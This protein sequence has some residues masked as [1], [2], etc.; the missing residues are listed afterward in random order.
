MFTRRIIKKI[1]ALITQQEE[2]LKNY[3]PL[4]PTYNIK[5]YLTLSEIKLLLTLP[6]ER[7]NKFFTQF[8]DF[9]WQRIQDTNC[10]Y[11]HDFQ[12][13]ANVVCMALAREISHHSNQNYLCLLMPT[14]NQVSPDEYLTS[15]YIN[16]LDLKE[17]I[18]SDNNQRIINLIDV[19]NG[20]QE[21]GVLK[22]N[23]LFR[24]QI[25][26][27][28]FYEINRIISRHPAI[29]SMVENLN[30]RVL[31]KNENGDHYSRN[32]TQSGWLA[33]GGLE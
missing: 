21:D 18:L 27:L 10:Q 4:T 23:S 1:S 24:G 5:A 2:A 6:H 25:K 15:S 16:K 13:P 30:A 31:Y 11:L 26:A 7:M 28:S 29:K 17:L 20:A 12:N 9:R 8:F 32:T 22:Y 33:G 3:S 19:L 14:L